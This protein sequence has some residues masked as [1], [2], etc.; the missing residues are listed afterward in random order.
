VLCRFGAVGV[1]TIVVAGAL[2]AAAGVGG[3]AFL[4]TSA[5]PEPG[6]MEALGIASGLLMLRRRVRDAKGVGR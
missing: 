2:R 6:S 1:V 4:F 3:A 5:V